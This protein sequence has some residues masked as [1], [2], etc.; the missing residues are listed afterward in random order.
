MVLALTGAVIVKIEGDLMMYKKR[1][2]KCGMLDLETITAQ[3]PRHESIHESS[4]RC[5]KCGTYQNIRIRGE[6]TQ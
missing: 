6:Q 2:E 5:F 3:S 4:F 1:C